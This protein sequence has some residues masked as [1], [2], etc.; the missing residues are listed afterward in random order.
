MNVSR[1]FSSSMLG[2]NKRG[3]EYLFVKL[4]CA[5][6]AGHAP[7]TVFEIH[8]ARAGRPCGVVA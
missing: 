2:S 5:V 3:R 6:V 4:G 7:I 1:D 8:L